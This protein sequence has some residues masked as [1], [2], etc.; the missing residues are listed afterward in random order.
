[1]REYE[2]VSHTPRISVSI[3]MVSAHRI[4]FGEPLGA[5]GAAEFFCLG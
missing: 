1:M 3:A 4:C 5:N 2:G